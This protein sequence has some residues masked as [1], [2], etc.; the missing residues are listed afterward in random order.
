L[1]LFRKSKF[2]FLIKKELKNKEEEEVDE[3]LDFVN[4]LDY[5]SYINDLE[6]SSMV[7]I[8]YFL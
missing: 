3:L 4:N 6:V 8:K 5:D 1:G 7:F 2:N